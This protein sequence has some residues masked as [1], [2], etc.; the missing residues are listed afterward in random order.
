MYIVVLSI[1]FYKILNKKIKE[2]FLLFEFLLKK[3]YI[4]SKLFIDI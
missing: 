3:L 1:F 4:L 2:S